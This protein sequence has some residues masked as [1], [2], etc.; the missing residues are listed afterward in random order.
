M[1]SLKA[2]YKSPGPRARLPTGDKWKMSAQSQ[3]LSHSACQNTS[4]SGTQK[5]LWPYNIYIPLEHNLKRPLKNIKTSIAFA[6]TK[7]KKFLNNLYSP[8][9]N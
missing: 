2:T 6:F 3:L 9:K 4:M 8:L 5:H 7:V 1:G